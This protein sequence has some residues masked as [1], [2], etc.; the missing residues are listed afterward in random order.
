MKKFSLLVTGILFF[1]SLHA[2]DII[3]LKNG[4]QLRGK[5]VDVNI[6]DVKYIKENNADTSLQTVPKSDIIVID[7]KDGST[8]ML[9]NVVP[10]DQLKGESF[11]KRL[12]LAVGGCLDYQFPQNYMYKAKLNFFPIVSFGIIASR[13]VTF[14]LEANY[15]IF[16][17]SYT[18][19]IHSAASPIRTVNSESSMRTNLYLTPSVVITA[20]KHR[21]TPFA[22]MGTEIS[23]INKSTFSDD[24]VEYKNDVIV[25]YEPSKS[26]ET[27]PI[28]VGVL[29]AGGTTWQ[30]AKRFSVFGEL[31]VRGIIPPSASAGLMLDINSPSVGAN[32]GLRIA[33]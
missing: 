12:Y 22:R 28:N 27:Y 14:D 25:S 15:Q 26:T 24:N 1:V 4:T 11:S 20:N 5:V 33:L 18:D 6:Y 19:D 10:S 9:N 13:R 3:T 2:Q 32:L 30:L 8:L 31:Y 7:Y 17:Y 23:A 21:F 29:L 16:N